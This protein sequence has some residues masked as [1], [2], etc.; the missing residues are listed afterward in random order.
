MKQFLKIILLSAGLTGCA[1]EVDRT[2]VTERS[3]VNEESGCRERHRFCRANCQTEHP[4]S[5]L[6]RERCFD[7][8]EYQLTSCLNSSSLIVQREPSVIVE[9]YAPVVVDPYPNVFVQPYTFWGG[10]GYYHHHYHGFRH[11]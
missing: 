11:R 9:P 2:V 10:R 6:G 1:Y 8:C 7:H 3:F 4:Y 5:A